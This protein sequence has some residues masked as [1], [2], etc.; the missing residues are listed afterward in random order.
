MKEEKDN[1]KFSQRKETFI[2]RVL[3]K[4]FIASDTFPIGRTNGERE[5]FLLLVTEF[6]V[7]CHE[8]FAFSCC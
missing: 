3:G 2:G 7:A 5:N 6:I 1:E 8:P 4:Q